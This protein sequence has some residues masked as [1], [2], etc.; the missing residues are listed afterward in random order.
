MIIM[1]SITTREDIDHRLLINI[2]IRETEHCAIAIVIFSTRARFP[3]YPELDQRRGDFYFSIRL[4]FNARSLLLRPSPVHTQ[5]VYCRTIFSILDAE[6][7]IEE[8]SAM[9]CLFF[10]SV[11]FSKPFRNALDWYF[12]WIIFRTSHLFF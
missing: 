7:I 8:S 2:G 6:L 11:R 5:K 1:C 9:Q 4:E 10:L 12:R 3:V